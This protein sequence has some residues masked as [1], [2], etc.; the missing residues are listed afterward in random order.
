MAA[1]KTV[2]W[3]LYQDSKNEESGTEYRTFRALR[4]DGVLLEKLTTHKNGKTEHD[5]G[6]KIKSRK[7]R[8]DILKYLMDRGWQ[9][10]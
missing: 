3:E 1:K 2:S 7:P 4:S 9:Q 8:E 6:W 5:W 10:K